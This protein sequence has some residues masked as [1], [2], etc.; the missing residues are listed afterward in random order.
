MSDQQLE[1]AKNLGLYVHQNVASGFK[2]VDS[3]DLKVWFMEGI[4]HSYHCYKNARNTNS[5]FFVQLPW[6]HDKAYLKNCAEFFEKV[7]GLE[8]LRVIV[9]ANSH[10]ELAHSIS[11]G[12]K[13]SVLVPHNCF[14]DYELMTPVNVEKKYD[15]V[16]NTRPEKWKR[17]FL[18]EKVQ[19]LAIIKGAN[20][21][22]SDFYD[23]N[24]LKPL[25]INNERIGPN[26]VS[27]I[28]CQSYA[29]G[30]FSAVEGGCYSSSEYLLLGLPVISTDCLGGR[31]IWYTERN[32][33]KVEDNSSAVAVGVEKA[34][35]MVMNGYFDPD[36]IR[37]DHILMSNFYRSTFVDSLHKVVVDF[38][39]DGEVLFR[40][41]Y[42][43]KFIQY[44]KI[45]E[46]GK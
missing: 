8:R 16:L 24:Q 2:L 11:V 22:P 12:F 41:T 39:I 32:S 33:L 5:W 40:E 21:R 14:L 37:R 46:N 15:L 18:A 10:I 44:T 20:H 3:P 38:G 17:P 1:L 19:K 9:L 6:H 30:I 7:T 36:E 42:K 35:N 25:F 45:D 26:D 29:G 34:K 13:Y 28:L 23:L 4:S 31:D 27:K 43:H